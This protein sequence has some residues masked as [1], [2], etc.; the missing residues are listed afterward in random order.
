MSETRMNEQTQEQRSIQDKVN[1]ICNELYAQGNKVSVRMVCSMLPD[2]SS[3]S[4]VHKYYK[5]WKDE[6]EANSQSLYEKLGFSEKFTKYFMQ[7]VTRF[8]VEAEQRYKQLAEDA[9]DQRDRAIEDLERAEERLFKQSSLLDQTQKEVKTL[10]LVVSE[11]VKQANQDLAAANSENKKS[12]DAMKAHV[13]EVMQLCEEKTLSQAQDIKAQNE[14]NESLRTGLAKAELRLESHVSQVAEH[15]KTESYL[16][17]VNNA[18]QAEKSELS[19]TAAEL[20]VKES[21]GKELITELKA[22]LSRADE[23]LSSVKSENNTLSTKVSNLETEVTASSAQIKSL[24]EIAGGQVA[25]IAQKDKIIDTLQLSIHNTE[26]K[27]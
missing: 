21:A 26:S 13:E 19:I 3:V 16:T 15:K 11:H 2:L 17:S 10:D 18:L 4:S 7:E 5:V 14:A 1:D 27:T 23:Q 25:N 12:L 20:R 8:A 22:G 24:E 6:T 9:N